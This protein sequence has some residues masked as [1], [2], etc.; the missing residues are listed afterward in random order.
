M[1][2]IICGAGGFIGQNLVE[3]FANM[4]NDVRAIYSLDAILP[5]VPS[6][7]SQYRANLTDRIDVDWAIDDCDLLLQFAASTSGS[8]VIVNNPAVHVTDNAIM[9]S[10]ILRRTLE[11]K[12]GHYI[13]PSCSVMYPSSLLPQTE[14]SLDFNNP[15]DKKYFGV[16]NTK[17]YIEKMCQFYSQIT[18]TKFT[19]IRHSNIYGPN[20]KFDPATSHVFASLLKKIIDNN[21]SIE[22][23]GDGQE[24]RDLLYIDDLILFIE[25][26]I[27]WQRN[28]FDLFNVGSGKLIQIEKLA[29]IMMEV[30]EK[31]LEIHYNKDKPTIPVNILL[32]C[33]KA[34]EIIGWEPTTE[35]KT[36]IKKTYE[37]YKGKYVS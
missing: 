34:K 3:Y 1:K 35:I 33:D 13:F 11:C 2:I 22:I 25:N 4:G 28:K 19:V 23:W 18:D 20:D 7:V 12:I 14:D 37:W 17:L 8:N 29:K 31:D 36:G 21:K 9:N 26:V 10:L 6:H 16:G 27:Y 30:L 15:I 24:G 5:K 32:N